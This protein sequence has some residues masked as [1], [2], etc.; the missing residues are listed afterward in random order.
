M[1]QRDLE[2]VARRCLG[3][4]TEVGSDLRS[5]YDIK[6]D[7]PKPENFFWDDTD[8]NLRRLY[9]M[10]TG[11]VPKL[12]ADAQVIGWEGD[13]G[14]IE[15]IR[16]C[17]DIRQK[18][19]NSS[20]FSRLTSDGP[21]VEAYITLIEEVSHFTY[22]HFYYDTYGKMPEPALAELIAV[23]DQYNVFQLQ[24]KRYFGQLV[25]KKIATKLFED[26]AGEYN[27]DLLGNTPGRYVIGHRLGTSYL[28]YLN[29]LHN[30]GG[31]AGQ[32][33]NDFYHMS[34]SEQLHHLLYDLQLDFR[35]YSEEEEVEMLDI[36]K[37]LGVDVYKDR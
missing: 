18:I 34:N 17:P 10:N 20:P 23:I 36:C 31:G 37:N 4:V 8:D 1:N 33:L 29:R 32:E 15:I 27:N 2:K 26:Q 25:D 7:L 9:K 16:L 14:L 5:V 12:E 21:S 24:S 28:S 30:G 22:V 35:T 11:V 3:P 19:A 6:S 13:N